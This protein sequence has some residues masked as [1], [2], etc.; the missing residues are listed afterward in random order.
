MAKPKFKRR[1]VVVV[2]VHGINVT[3][4]D[5]YVPMRDAILRGLPRAD[6][7][8]VV[9]RAAFWADLLRG[10]Q[11]EY[12]LYAGTRPGFAPTKLHSMV[13]EGLGDAAAYQ[14][15]YIQNSAYFDIQA[16]LRKAISD[17]STG[18]EDRR[19]L[20]LVTH[21]LGCHIASSYAW[22]IHKLRDKARQELIE[23]KPGEG[24]A[25]FRDSDLWRSHRWDSPF[26]C[27]ETFAGL[28]SMGSNQPLFTFNIGPQYVHPITKSEDPSKPAAFPGAALDPNTRA[29]ARFLNFYSRNDPLGYPLKP[30][31]DAYDDEPLLQDI[32]THSEGW[33]RSLLCR[34][35]LRQL[36]A[37]KAHSGYWTNRVVVRQS[38]QLISN[39]INADALA[40]KQA[41]YAI[42]P[43]GPSVPD[44][45][46][47]EK[48]AGV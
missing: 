33:V 22:D 15:S 5:Y 12:L 28:I 11:Q 26:E 39:L 41:K 18:P 21:S 32:H 40:A 23:N 46:A 24:R 35:W 7:E 27:L 10:R 37:M 3:R 29:Q 16:R 38:A 31:N 6:R 14:K 44:A 45:E 43:P 25:S 4:Q 1:D 8:C 34:G 20:V 36:A 2:F 17:A 48:S 9:F 13:I 30:L 42:T 47:G 19:P